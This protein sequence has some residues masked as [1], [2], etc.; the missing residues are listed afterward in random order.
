MPGGQ[1]AQFRSVDKAYTCEV[2]ITN[3]VTLAGGGEEGG[4][5]EET[6]P[7]PAPPAVW[8]ALA[9]LVAVMLRYGV[10]LSRIAYVPIPMLTWH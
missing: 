9:D 2:R 8:V 4:E 10:P 6:P 7:T 5:E 1:V 3:A